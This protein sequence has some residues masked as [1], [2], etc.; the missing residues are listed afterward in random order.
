MQPSPHQSDGSARPSMCWCA[1]LD[2]GR[3]CAE[4]AMP[5]VQDA[6][7]AAAEGERAEGW[8]VMAVPPQTQLKE[9]R[10]TRPRCVPHLVQG[11]PGGTGRDTSCSS[12]PRLFSG[13]RERPRTAAARPWPH[14]T[15]ISSG[16]AAR[17]AC[18]CCR[19]H[20]S[21]APAAAAA[22][23]RRSGRS[24]G[25]RGGRQAECTAAAL[26]GLSGARS[27]ARPAAGHPPADGRA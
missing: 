14:G 6:A 23:G 17:A 11:A 19:S 24:Q 7:A 26:A 5:R 10:C 13:R 12:W 15:A 22:S 18:S 3:A 1:P 21:Q 2:H 27:C 9:E 16:A 8:S 25:Q 4:C 20:T